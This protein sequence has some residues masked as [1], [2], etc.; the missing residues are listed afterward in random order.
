MAVVGNTL[1]TGLESNF[2]VLPMPTRG[3][4]PKWMSFRRT[5]SSYSGQSFA[6]IGFSGVR[7]KHR[8]QLD[9]ILMSLSFCFCP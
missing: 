4:D 5:D 7:E 6:I 9:V 1:D 8:K 2:D 3:K